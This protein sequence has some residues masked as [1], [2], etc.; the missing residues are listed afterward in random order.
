MAIFSHILWRLGVRAAT[1]PRIRAKAAEIYQEEVKPRADAAWQ[2]AKPRID[3]AKTE[4]EEIAHEA[5][6]RQ[7]PMKFARRLKERLSERGRRR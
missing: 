3:A 1:D 2:Q 4:I 5:D 6:P 7:D